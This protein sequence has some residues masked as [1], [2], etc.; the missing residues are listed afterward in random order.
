MPLTCDA[1]VAREHVRLEVVGARVVRLEE[2]L[3]VADLA[4]PLPAAEL[5]EVRRDVGA[6]KQQKNKDP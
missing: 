4:L 3:H 6:A 5:G 1:L 2:R